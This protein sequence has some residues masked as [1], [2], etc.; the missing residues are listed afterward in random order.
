ME[1]TENKLSKRSLGVLVTPCTPI[2]RSLHTT[3][4]LHGMVYTHFPLVL[5]LLIIFSFYLTL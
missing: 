4:P 5:I 2:I 1:T 3:M